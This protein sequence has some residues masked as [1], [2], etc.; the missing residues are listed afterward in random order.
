MLL[1]LPKRTKIGPDNRGDDRHRANGQRQGH[2]DGGTGFFKEDRSQ[3]HGCNQSHRVGFKQVCRHAGTV[4]NIVTDIVRDGCGVAR[5]IFWD[6]CFNLTNH[7]AANVC[8]LGEDTAAETRKD[9]DQGCP[10]TQ[11]DQG[12]DHFA[13]GWL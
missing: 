8:T 5:I 3:H 7:I 11:G 1:S 13:A 6:A 12:I 9:R 10:K 2:H 4:A